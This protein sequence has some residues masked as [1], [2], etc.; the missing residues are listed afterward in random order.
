MQ[1]NVTEEENCD[2]NQEK[3]NFIF[4]DRNDDID[5]Y[6]YEDQ[7]DTVNVMI[8]S[9]FFDFVDSEVLS[10]SSDDDWAP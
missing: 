9:I 3:R 10:T 5:S 7:T 8:R 6:L 1:S 2:R 4:T